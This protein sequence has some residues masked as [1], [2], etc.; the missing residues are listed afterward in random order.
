MCDAEVD[1]HER[2]F[3]KILINFAKE[4]WLYLVLYFAVF[5]VTGDIFGMFLHCND[6]VVIIVHRMK[7]YF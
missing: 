7:V 2:A 5:S 3:V 4:R 1:W 6:E